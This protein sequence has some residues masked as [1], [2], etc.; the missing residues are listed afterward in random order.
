MGVGL[1]VV[2]DDGWGWLI[3]VPPDLSAVRISLGLCFLDNFL[4]LLLTHA[5]VLCPCSGP[6]DPSICPLQVPSLFPV[7][8]CYPGLL[9]VSASRG[10][11]FRRY[12]LNGPIDQDE[13]WA[14]V[15]SAFD[16]IFNNILLRQKI[17]ILG[18]AID[19]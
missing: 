13:T 4:H 19:S 15:V 10:P 5:P 11:V 2:I 18:L 14:R 8:L 6:T 9:S 7:A 12:I 3:P 16:L 17:E 1:S